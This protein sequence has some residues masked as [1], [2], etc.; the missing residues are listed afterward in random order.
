MHTLC[1]Q[2][3]MIL[4]AELSGDQPQICCCRLLN[5]DIRPLLAPELAR[6]NITQALN[7]VYL[8]Y[9]TTVCIITPTRGGWGGRGQILAQ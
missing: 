9:S 7:G 6:K 3:Q 1:L 5:P 4:L 8:M 2:F